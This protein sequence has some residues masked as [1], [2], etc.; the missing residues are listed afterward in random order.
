[1][2]GATDPVSGASD[3]AAS[4]FAALMD[5]EALGEARFA[6]PP[7][8]ER[9]GDM[10]GGQFLAQ[11]LGAAH[12]TV[13]R[14]RAVHSL[15]AYFLRPGDVGQGLEYT[16]ERVRD[17]RSFS[18]RSV[19]ARQGGK[20]L[21]RMTASYHVPEPGLAYAARELP[22]VPPPEDVELTYNAFSRA[23]GEAPDW[24]GEARPM[25]IRYVNPP[26]AP[27]GEPVLEDQRLWMRMT[28]V[29]PE[30]PALHS[31]GLAYLSDSTLIDHVV[32][33]HGRRWQDPRLQSTSLDHAMWF[34]RPARADGWLL[35]DQSVEATGA[36]RG[37]A[38]GRLFDR[39]GRLV[40]TCAQEGLIR[41][42]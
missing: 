38:T 28:E 31:A 2:T 29:L 13:E 9:T 6:A 41:W 10:Y 26:T 18:W 12:R 8:P 39:E 14:N 7:A 20:E 1:M 35:F 3:D 15:H 36:A 27:A 5:L 17:G 23:N 37:L 4:A 11:G 22:T 42:T 16:V 33:P 25:D 32:L 24:D 30:D 21:F 19:V 34:H 40:A